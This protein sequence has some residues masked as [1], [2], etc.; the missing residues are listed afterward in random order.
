[1]TA[2]D[3]LQTYIV[4]NIPAIVA[5]LSTV[6]A[7]I[8]CAGG[9]KKIVNS[10]TDKVNTL[11]QDK[12]LEE[13]VNQNKILLEDNAKLRKQ[14]NQLIEIEGKVRIDEKG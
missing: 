7:Y 8:K 1:M 11:K 9:A 4:P 13:L 6:A 14:L 2:A 12:L 10:V 5:T 3:I